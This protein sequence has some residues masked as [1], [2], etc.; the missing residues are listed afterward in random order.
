MTIQ[1]SRSSNLLYTFL[2]CSIIAPKISGID[3]SILTL[4]LLCCFS[5]IKSRK[6]H[7]FPPNYYFVLVVW[8]ILLTFTLT[9]YIFFGRIDF[10]FILKPCRQIVL[11]SLILIIIDRLQLKVEHVFK[12]IIIAALI[13]CIII[14]MQLV[15]HNYFSISG[16]MLPSSFNEEVDAPFRK[17]GLMSGYPHAGILSLIALQCLIYFNRRINRLLFVILF[18]FLTLSLIVTSRTA[19]LLAIVPF[20]T[21]FMRGF[22]SKKALSGIILFIGIGIS[23]ITYIINMLP[24][25]TFT[26]SFELFL[27][28]SESKSFNTLSTDASIESYML[29]LKTS[30]WLLGNGKYMTN[31]YNLNVDDGFQ[32][33][34]YGGGVIY[35]I[36]T[37]CLYFYYF[38][39]STYRLKPTFKK[40]TIGCIFLIVFIA[41]FKLDTIFTRVISD[42]LTLFFAIGLQSKYNHEDFAQYS[43]K[44]KMNEVSN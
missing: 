36:I 12:V 27:N 22:K 35:L 21:F 42:I 18:S 1:R 2:A 17:P 30:T 31:D 19:L 11:L 37:I 9:S 5:M 6:I 24:E 16:F 40:Y 26:H 38:F 7:S 13:N 33:P 10:Q 25:D 20:V 43:F 34:L 23:L 15:G 28:Y 3:F 44:G 29:P 4:I 32:I 39:K 14:A 8:L 41:N